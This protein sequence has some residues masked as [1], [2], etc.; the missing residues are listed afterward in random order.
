MPER[1]NSHGVWGVEVLKNLYKKRQLRRIGAACHMRKFT[2]AIG[3]NSRK[4]AV[5]VL[6]PGKGF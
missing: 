1:R 5:R 3:L 6:I 4:I 2:T